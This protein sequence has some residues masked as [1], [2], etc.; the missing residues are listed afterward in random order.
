[1]VERG[2]FNAVVGS[3]TL[4]QFTIAEVIQLEEWRTEN[5]YEGV[6]VTPSALDIIVENCYSSY[7]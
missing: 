4:S 5:P 7:C 1:M 2:T 6:Q 3:S